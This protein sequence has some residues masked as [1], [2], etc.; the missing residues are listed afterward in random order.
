MLALLDSLLDLLV[1]P[2]SSFNS[3]GRVE[4]AVVERGELLELLLNVLDVDLLDDLVDIGLV[5][6]LLGEFAGGAGETST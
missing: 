2:L 6:E 1:E 3:E 4:V 5:S